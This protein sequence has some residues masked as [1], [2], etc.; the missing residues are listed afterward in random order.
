MPS[1]GGRPLDIIVVMVFA[2]VR[3]LDDISAQTN[4]NLLDIHMFDLWRI[5][6]LAVNST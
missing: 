2:Q 3:P 5:G 1:A 6:R 4:N